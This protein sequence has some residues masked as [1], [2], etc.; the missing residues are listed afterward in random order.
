MFSYILTESPA[1]DDMKVD[2]CCKADT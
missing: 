1:V 2:E